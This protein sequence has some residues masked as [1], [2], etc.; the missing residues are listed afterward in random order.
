VLATHLLLMLGYEWVGS[1][2]PPPVRACTGVWRSEIFC[3]IEGQ[4]I[5]LA[6]GPRVQN[7]PMD[8][9]T[10]TRLWKN[11]PSKGGSIPGRQKRFLSS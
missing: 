2:P 10:V 5:K 3:K 7:G 1:I 6:I 4:R 9:V 8:D 11:R